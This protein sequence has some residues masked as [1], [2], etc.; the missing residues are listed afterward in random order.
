MDPQIFLKVVGHHT[1]LVLGSFVTLPR[2]VDLATDLQVD[3]LEGLGRKWQ[4]AMWQGTAGP[5]GRPIKSVKLPK[6]PTMASVGPR[7]RGVTCSISSSSF[8]DASVIEVGVWWAV[9]M[10]CPAVE[11][12]CCLLELGDRVPEG[13]GV[14]LSAPWISAVTR[15]TSQLEGVLTKAISNTG[16]PLI[17]GGL[18]IFSVLPS[19]SF[20][21]AATNK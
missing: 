1:F 20:S 21:T 7:G 13:G 6:G 15:S 5:L 10:D 16:V 18:H 4:S 17:P 3:L 11:G 8:R 9:F 2:H 14:N 19:P 12:T